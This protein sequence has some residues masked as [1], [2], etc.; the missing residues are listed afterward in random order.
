MSKRNL[1]RNNVFGFVSKC[2]GSVIKCD[3]MCHNVSS[4]I[5][6][7]IVSVTGCDGG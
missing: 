7:V 5:E 1:I 4:C 2:D 6:N 3:R